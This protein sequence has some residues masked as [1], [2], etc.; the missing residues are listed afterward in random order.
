MQKRHLLPF[1]NAFKLCI[2]H[3][4]DKRSTVCITMPLCDFTNPLAASNARMQSFQAVN[5]KEK[6]KTRGAQKE[7]IATGI[8]FRLRGY[9]VSILCFFF[10]RAAHYYF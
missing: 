1:D 9:N 8:I 2:F 5:Q 6:R 3:D 4:C 7:R 10:C